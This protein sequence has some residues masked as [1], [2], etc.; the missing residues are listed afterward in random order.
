[1]RHENGYHRMLIVTIH[2]IAR[3]LE[4]DGAAHD[5]AGAK[6][7]SC[8][9]LSPFAPSFSPH[10]PHSTILEHQHKHPLSSLLH[11]SPDNRHGH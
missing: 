2:P 11:L 7:P 8:S 5:G 6:S 10:Q 1:M 4:D 9:T 3:A